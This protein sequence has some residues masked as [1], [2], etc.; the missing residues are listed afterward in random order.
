MSATNGHETPAEALA[1]LYD[2]DLHD[3]PGDLEM[4]TAVARG[5]RRAL[6]ELMAGSGR[7]AVPLAE[8]GHEVTAVDLDPRCSP[9]P[10]AGRPPPDRRSRGAF[11]SSWRT[12]WAWPS[13]RPGLPPGLRRLNSILLLP[14]RAAQQAA[15][16]ALAA[17]LGPGGVA[18]VDTWLPDAHDLSRYDGRLHLEYHRPDPETGRWVTKTAAARTTPPPRPSP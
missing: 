14:S 6:L 15:W 18:A 13:K 9:V 1:R 5:G 10:A 16:V 11:T 8:E 3:D 12:W 17:H 2:L 7:L 4:W